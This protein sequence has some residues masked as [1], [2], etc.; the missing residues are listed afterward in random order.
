M[1][2]RFI[3]LCFFSTLKAD[4]EPVSFYAF[5]KKKFPTVKAFVIKNPEL[6]AAGLVLIM[7]NISYQIDEQFCL[8]GLPEDLQKLPW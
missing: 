2:K 5:F 8:H 4:Q 3:F 7:Q 6:I 1:M